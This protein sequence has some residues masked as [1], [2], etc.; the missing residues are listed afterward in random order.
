MKWK[1]ITF[2]QSKRFGPLTDDFLNN[3]GNEALE[4]VCVIEMRDDW[5]YTFK[6]ADLEV[7]GIEQ[8]EAEAEK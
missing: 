3:L 8:P 6:R 5:L 7:L 1:Y 4:L 2:S